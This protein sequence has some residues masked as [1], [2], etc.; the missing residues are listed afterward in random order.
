ME[1]VGKHPICQDRD[2]PGSPAVKTP[3]FHCWGHEFNPGW[4]NGDLTC[5]STAKNQSILFKRKKGGRGM[6]RL[7]NIQITQLISS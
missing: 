5:S 3:H 1:Q 2:F 4:E 6:G 7:N